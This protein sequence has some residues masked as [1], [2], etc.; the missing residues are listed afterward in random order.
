MNR[1]L[2]V[3]L[4]VSTLLAS[5]LGMQ[6]VHEAGHVLGAWLTGGEV[7]QVVWHPLTISRTDLTSNPQPLIVVWAGPVVGVLLPML[8]WFSARLL[9]TAA[10]FVWRFFAGFCLIANGA[11]IGIGSFERIGDCGEM[12][13]HGSPIWTLWMFGLLTIP[14][15]FAIWNRQATHFGIGKQAGNVESNVVWQAGLAAICLL[16]LSITLGGEL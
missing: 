15:G 4:I 13:D 16:I 6:L 2:Q 11:Y 1:L 14:L 8:F 12:L 7:K 9:R 10:E 3:V 5:W